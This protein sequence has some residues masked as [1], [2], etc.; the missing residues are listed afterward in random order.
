MTHRLYIDEVGNDDTDTASERYLSL[1]GIITKVRSH[2]NLITP[3]IEALKTR[4]FG[5]NPPQWPV[6]LHRREI[7]RRELPFDC[8]LDEAV[9]ADWEASILRLIEGLPYIAITVMI[10]KHEH[11]ER[12][13]VWLFN[14]YHYCMISLLERYVLWLHRHNH[15]GDVVAEPRYKS[16]DK[17]LKKAFNHFFDHGTPNISP[18]TIQAHISSREIKFEQKGANVCGLQLVELIAHPSH[19]AIKSQFT[20]EPMTAS[21]GQRIVEILMRVRYSRNRRTGRI[22]G[23]G[24][25]RLP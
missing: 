24:Q 17:K 16:Q 12:Y 15:K 13:K 18:A 22:E 19:Q 11:K 20:G 6:I 1:T 7:V 3:S 5:H 14:P 9:N 10:D 25:K 23:Y 21:F 8:L 2:D 4:I